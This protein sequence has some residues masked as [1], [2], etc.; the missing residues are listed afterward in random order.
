LQGFLMKKSGSLEFLIWYVLWEVL[1]TLMKQHRRMARE[2]CMWS[3]LPAHD[4][5]TLSMLQNRS[6]KSMAMI[7][8][9]VILPWVVVQTVYK[10]KQLL[11]TIS[12]NKCLLCK[13]VK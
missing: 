4:R 8:A 12:Q 9:K 1:K 2:W 10:N 13:K 7:R 3:G 5:Q 11:Q 6:E